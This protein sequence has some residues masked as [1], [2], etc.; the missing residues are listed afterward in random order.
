M[1]LIEPQSGTAFILKKG[2][3]LKVTDVEGGQVSDLACYLE[4]DSSES[5]SSGRTF[6]H[7]EKIL[8]TAGDIIFSQNDRPLLL[9]QEDTVGRHDFL[10]APCHLSMFQKD[11][12]NEKHHPSCHE[13]LTHSLNQ[14]GILPHQIGT[15]FNIFMNV[16]LSQ[17]GR[18][19]IKPPLSNR[20]DFIIFE[21]LQDLIVGLT[22]CSDELTNGFGF[23]K[24]GYEIVTSQLI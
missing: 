23:K 24:I 18:I 17:E 5:L 7:A 2:Q 10:Y 3:Q 13:N 1:K 6:D 15:T 4:L 8:L 16:Q 12:E 20:G 14:Y 11:S 19:S 9:I 22:A 21:A